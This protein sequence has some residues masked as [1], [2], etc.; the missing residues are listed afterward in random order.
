MTDFRHMATLDDRSKSGVSLCFRPSGGMLACSTPAPSIVVWDVETL[1]PVMNLSGHTTVG[2]RTLAFSPDGQ[3]LASGGD[4]G[5][6][7][8]FW[9]VEA[10][11]EWV[12]AVSFSPDD[13]FIVSAGDDG[14]VRLWDT[15][16]G[17]LVREFSGHYVAGKLFQPFIYAVAF[18]PDGQLLASGSAD[19]T[20]RL[21]EV[22]TGRELQVLALN[23]DV[24]ALAFSPDGALLAM[25]CA[26][27]AVQLWRR[28]QG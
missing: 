12:T 10:H 27:T 25:G 2:P 16:S 9:R 11:D 24:R 19:G 17:Q 4:A 26:R 23:D 3:L 20:V 13:Q 5:M 7:E 8:P 21:W 1:Q 15:W 6:P 22:D 18:A 28:E 14:V